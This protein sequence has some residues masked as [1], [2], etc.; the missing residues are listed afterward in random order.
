MMFQILNQVLGSQGGQGTIP[1]LYK[2]GTQ[3]IKK[4]IEHR[5][6]GSTEAR[7]RGRPGKNVEE[8]VLEGR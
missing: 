7:G 4:K 5:F 6:R 8:H 3:L 2:W 1:V